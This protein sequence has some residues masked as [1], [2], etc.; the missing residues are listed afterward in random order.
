LPGFRRRTRIAQCGGQVVLVLSRGSL[1]SPATIMT[2]E[3]GPG[4]DLLSH[5]ENGPGLF[6]GL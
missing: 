4:R 2:I 6:S 1:R 5:G 3:K